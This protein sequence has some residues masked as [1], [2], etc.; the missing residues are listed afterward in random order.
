[1]TKKRE[2]VGY[3]EMKKRKWERKQEDREG[4]GNRERE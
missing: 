2:K 1:M 4:M 3:E